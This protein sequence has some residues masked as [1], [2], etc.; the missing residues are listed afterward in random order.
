MPLK[1]ALI[2]YYSLSPFIKVC[3]LIVGGGAGDGEIQPS[4]LSLLSYPQ[5]LD[6]ESE[7][8]QVRVGD[9]ERETD[10]I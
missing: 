10:R 3:S 1:E 8:E 5:E 6:R 7:L 2:P 9:G 4:L